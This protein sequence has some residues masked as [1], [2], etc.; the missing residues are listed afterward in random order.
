MTFCLFCLLPKTLVALFTVIT[1]PYG[2]LN[3]LIYPATSI[4][5]RCLEICF[6]EMPS[7]LAISF[8]FTGLPP[9]ILPVPL[10]SILVILSKHHK[11][12]H[13]EVPIA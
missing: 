12:S 8:S 7:S 11:Y 13:N 10:S 4:F 5:F 3:K 6:S 2:V 1:K 9:S